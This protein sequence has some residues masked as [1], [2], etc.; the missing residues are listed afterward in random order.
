MGVPKVLADL[1]AR[2]GSIDPE[3]PVVG[4]LAFEVAA[5]MSRFVSLH[6]SLA[7]DEV[8]RLRTDMR[9]QGVAYLTSKDQPFLLRLACAELVAE[10]DKA[11]A[12][13]SRLAVKCQ[14]PLLRGFD[15]IYD[16]LKAGGACPVLRGGRVTEL[17]RFGLGSTAK[18]V[19]KRVKRVEKYVAATSLLYAEMEAMNA[20]EATERRMEQ[21][22]RHSGPIP[23]QKPGVSLAPSPI[24]LEL[25]SQR[26]KVRQLKKISLWNK[27]FDDAVDFMVRAVITVFARIS[28]VFGSCVLGLP[29]LQDRSR[30]TL[31]LRGSPDFPGK[32]SSGPLERPSKMDVPILRNSAPMF[33][34]NESLAKP[35][36]SLSNLLQA[37][38]RT[39]GGSGLV[40]RYANVIVA[41]EKLLITRSVEGHAAQ[42][43]EEVEEDAAAREELYHMMPSGM[44]ASVR[45]KLREC[46]RR[47]GGTVDGSLAEGW[48]E[49][50]G[51]ILSWLGPV[52][53][54]TLRWQEERN[55]ERHH[56]FHTRPMALL[57]QT[58]HFSDREKTEAA[59]VEV[60]VGLSC[61]CWYEDRGRE[62]LRGLVWMA[63][64]YIFVYYISLGYLWLF[65]YVS[66]LSSMAMASSYWCY[67]C[68]RFVR[69][70][71]QDAI[72]C[73][74]C[75]GG[76]L[77]EVGSPPPRLYPTA[78]PRRRRVPSTDAHA[79]GGDWSAA[80][81]PPR[82]SSELRFRRNRRSSAGDRF[83]FNPVIVLR[84]PS[85][86]GARDADRATTTS[87]ELY[88][89]DGTGSGLRPLPESI[90]DFLM[91]SGFDRLLEQLAQIEI[92]GIGR[93]RGC[94]HPPASKAAI[95]SM[96]AVE[97]V[98]DHIGK[99]CHCAICMDAFELGTV[100]REMPCKHIYH[101]DC[102]LP[103]LSLRNSCPVCRH[104]MPTDVQ[105]QGATGA[106]GDEQAAATGNEEETVGLTIWRLPGGGFA[107]GRFSGGRRAGEREFPVVYTEMDGGF[108]SS[109]APRRISWSSTISRSRGSG[110]IGR[111]IRNFF[112]S[113]R[114]S[115]SASSSSR[116]SS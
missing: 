13:V 63:Y 86:G 83:H 10:L 77:E 52:A 106:E 34:T 85:E 79:L 113:F 2:V 80:A 7:E 26:H 57:L 61:M 101:Q 42:N 44:R 39:V 37:G 81:A 1:R 92:N 75:D 22:R 103:W 82:H 109:G 112:S 51:R 20:L 50:V 14:D 6:R 91:G 102:I 9:S 55:I 33:M 98:D 108:N 21:Q 11:A 89:D 45:A 3:R 65:L 48:K 46:W 93:G 29:P 70:W 68:S 40:S 87:F 111:A 72:V 19:E 78:E 4:I 32:H 54:D 18:G 69:V 95:E 56:R 84:G 38:P 104:E 49:V 97:I 28:S 30:P 62:P 15:R 114:L 27:T 36:E 115:R 107:V 90:S 12:A 43:D 88:Y 58:L 41:A 99:D 47:E 76:F 116:P 17:E 59:I 74:N 8:R 16:V 64:R 110:G 105:A 100:A 23:V 24:Q 53:H 66:V 60:L 71:P 67:R 25:R 5:I 73:P 96:P 35:F 94:E 31:M